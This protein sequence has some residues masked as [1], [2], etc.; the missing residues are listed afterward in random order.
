MEYSQ[1]FIRYL[2]ESDVAAVSLSMD[3]V[4]EIVEKVY[5]DHGNG[6]FIMPTKSFLPI[7]ALDENTK[8][9][10]CIMSGYLKSCSMTG[11][12]WIG[13]N[14][15]NYKEFKI[16][17][18]QS[19][20]LLNDI[21]NFSPKAIIQSN[22]ITAARTGAATAVGIKYLTNKEFKNVTIIGAGYQ[23]IYQM[24]AIIQLNNSSNFFIY[25]ID[26][27]ARGNFIERMSKKFPKT[28]ITS[29]D[30]V[31]EGVKQ[32]EIIVT[33]T[34]AQ[35]TSLIDYSWLKPGILVCLLG[36]GRECS[37]E[38]IR[39]ADKIVVDNLS[40]CLHGAELRKWIEMGLMTEKH[41]Y[42]EIGEIVCGKKQGRDNNNEIIIF[43]PGGMVTL[44]IAVASKILKLAEDKNIG[45]LL[46]CF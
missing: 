41:I 24:E 4:I 40:Q 36:A 46:P 44:D 9:S 16:P 17:N 28:N 15:T 13:E 5:K 12:K 27:S 43:I 10:A 34:S 35:D 31:E 42:S 8:T 37:Y 25:D 20:V 3:Q 30:S 11:I 2:N 45:T 22:W 14:F 23:A 18:I 19:T 21:R 6:D 26:T 1:L 7:Y 32:S 29:I 39:K 38:V 33:V